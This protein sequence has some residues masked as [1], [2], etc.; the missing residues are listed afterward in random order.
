MTTFTIYDLL[1]VTLN[2]AERDADIDD[3]RYALC[4]LAD[5]KLM[6]EHEVNE[7]L[8]EMIGWHFDSDGVLRDAADNNK[9]LTYA[10]C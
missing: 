9:V 7:M 3:L 10:D 6:D 5:F 2:N 4:T 1:T 8:G